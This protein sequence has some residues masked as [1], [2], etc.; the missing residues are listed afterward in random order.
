MDYQI[1]EVH[2]TITFLES[3]NSVSIEKKCQKAKIKQSSALWASILCISVC[4]FHQNVTFLSE[5]LSNVRYIFLSGW[6]N[7]CF[8]DLL[9]D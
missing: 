6:N 4:E 8:L 9:L 1:I 3:W 5:T 7:G 2:E